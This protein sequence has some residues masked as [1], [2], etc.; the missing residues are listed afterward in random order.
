MKPR[1]AR[2]S[3]RLALAMATCVWLGL[4]AGGLRA[5]DAAARGREILGKWEKSVITL[6][7]TMKM[8]MSAE[9]R[10]M[11]EEESTQE[12]R[13]TMIDPSGLVVCSLSEADPSQMFAAYMSEEEGYKWEVDITAVKIRLADGK[14]IPAKIVLRDKDL[15]LAFVRPTEKQAQAFTAISLS[16]AGKAEVL[17]DVVILNRLGEVVNRVASAVLDQIAAIA[18]K[19]RMLYV[20]GPNGQSNALGCPVFALDG[21]LV[22]ILVNRVVS[23]GAAS[24][25]EDSGM[26]TV[27]LP[28]ADVLE[29]ANQAPQAQ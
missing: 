19:P 23:G 4:C 22:G 24:M 12:I 1:G 11:Q 28:T 25:S 20:P 5:D 7:L 2:V 9:G 13:A 8:R 14:E 3:G 26:L 27:I 21:K 10:Q 16:D 6:R 17:D 18:Q 29:V 15:D